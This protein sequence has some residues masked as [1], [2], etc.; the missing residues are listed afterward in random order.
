[1]GLA[2][3]GFEPDCLAIFGNGFV[4]F[5]GT[6]QC[7]AQA[8]QVVWI[9]GPL[10]FASASSLSASSDFPCARRTVPRLRCAAAW[11]GFNLIAVRYAVM[12]SSSF[13]C[14]CSD[15]AKIELILGIVEA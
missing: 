10:R 8:K 1:M 11:S 14:S 3:A 15:V 12:A 5:S 4:Q 7:E 9:A 13:C 2:V 6:C